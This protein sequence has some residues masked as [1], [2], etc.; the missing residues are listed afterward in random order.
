MID[1]L[2]YNSFIGLVIVRINT[3]NSDLAVRKIKMVYGDKFLKLPFLFKNN[4]HLICE[5]P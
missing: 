2:V 3:D 5:N 4:S 1:F